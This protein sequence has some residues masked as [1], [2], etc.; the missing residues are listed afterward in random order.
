[1][2]KR[3]HIFVISGPSGVGKG[4][5]LAL[6]LKEHPEISLSISATTRLPRPQETDGINYFF[7]SKEDFKE[8][9]KKDR[10]LEWAEFAGNYYGT[11]KNLVENA[12]N[13]EKDIALEID[14]Q[15]AIQIKNKIKDA[16]LIFISPPSMEELEQRLINRNTESKQVIE[17]RLA[18]VKSEIG[19]IKEFDYEVVNDKLEDA[20]KKLEA[21][22]LAQRCKIIKK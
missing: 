7:I 21:I 11:Y 18:I 12:L 8:K 9:I 2:K 17:K 6:L 5:L 15:G 14:V 10:F 19:K 4:T 22:I 3:G 20:L 1:M 16:I 13:D